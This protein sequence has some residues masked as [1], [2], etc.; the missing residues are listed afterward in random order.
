MRDLS[1]QTNNNKKK[2][3]D[4]SRVGE[5]FDPKEILSIVKKSEVS[6]NS[7]HLL[8]SSILKFLQKA[9]G[10]KSQLNSTYRSLIS[11]SNALL[12]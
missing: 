1:S 11:N 7:M 6:L 2:S 9:L 10:I 3:C 12:K 8:R 4:A 5:P